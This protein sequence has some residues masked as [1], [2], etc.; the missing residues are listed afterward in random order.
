MAFQ[1]CL[2]LG[3]LK[4]SYNFFFSSQRNYPDRQLVLM[5]DLQHRISYRERCSYS[6]L[7]SQYYWPD[8]GRCNAHETTE[9]KTI[10]VL[11]CDP[12]GIKDRILHKPPNLELLFSLLANKNGRDS[13]ASHPNLNGQRQSLVK[14]D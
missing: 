7:D 9:P 4:K 5:S 1:N 11:V 8:D 13:Y 12:A 14:K 3:R 2:F 10:W 6:A